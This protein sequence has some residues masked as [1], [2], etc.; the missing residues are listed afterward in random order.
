M[1]DGKVIH[2]AFIVSL[3]IFAPFVL[4][5]WSIRVAGVSIGVYPYGVKSWDVPTYEADWVVNRL[6]TLDG[7]L[8]MVGLLVLVSGV[9]AL[10]GS[11]KFRRF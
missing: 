4:P 11:L 1:G 5:W 9:L 3:A 7:T 6:L 8:L 10:A 2:V